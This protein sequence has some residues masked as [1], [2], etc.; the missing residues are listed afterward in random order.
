[1]DGNSLSVENPGVS[2]VIVDPAVGNEG[3]VGSPP[4][5]GTSYDPQT[6]TPADRVAAIAQ[7]LMQGADIPA[8]STTPTQP[9]PQVP[10]EPEPDP[11]PQPEVPDKFRA[12]D[13]SVNV[14]ALLKSYQEA[15]KKISSQG[16]QSA[17]ELAELRQ[18]VMQ[19]QTA[20][21]TNQGEPQGEPGTYAPP[22][23][24]TPNEEEL[25]VQAEAWL[26]KFYENPQGALQ[27]VISSALQQQI[28]EALKPIMQKVD[29][30]VQQ[31]EFRQSVQGYAQQMAQLSE[32]YLDV[33]QMR[34]AMQ[35]LL[36]SP[37]P[38]VKRKM[39]TILEMDDAM[40][41]IYL[42]AKG[43]TQVASPAAKTPEELLQDPAFLARAAQS[44]EVQKIILQS[45]QQQVQGE[46][47]PAVV[48]ARPGGTT[49]GMEPINIRST[50][51]AARASVDYFKK[52][53]GNTP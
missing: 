4:E 15:E 9:E 3:L 40:E 46:P 8:P 31:E 42:M 23:P 35:E 10:T 21:L 53:F 50:K 17:T 47:K 24:P 36:A 43:Q 28:G 11:E 32:K 26:E 16:Q 25:A 5:Q 34:P 48:G 38:A 52:A 12:P 18:T 20:L 30:I 39:E 7:R 2:Q 1:M 33:E 49:P 19:L 41:T 27:D 14:A 51:D 6:T 13:G 45:I 29:P 44:P 22:A 37:D